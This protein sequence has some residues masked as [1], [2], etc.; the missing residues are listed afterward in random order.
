M[1][2]TVTT[3]EEQADGGTQT[4]VV[5]EFG[6]TEGHTLWRLPV[7]NRDEA[8]CIRSDVAAKIRDLLDK[9]EEHWSDSGAWIDKTRP[10]TSTV[11]LIQDRSRFGE[12]E[13]QAARPGR[14]ANGT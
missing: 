9:E 10:Q 12:G 4:A 11:V 8:L 2:L 1:T 5:I 3:V 6:T 13:I 7:K 14:A